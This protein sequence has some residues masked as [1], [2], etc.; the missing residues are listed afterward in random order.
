MQQFLVLQG[1][2]DLDESDRSGLADALT[3]R[4]LR[5]VLKSQNPFFRAKINKLP[6]FPPA[7]VEFSSAFFKRLLFRA[8][9]QGYMDS[10][11]NAL[12]VNVLRRILKRMFYLLDD[13][14][15]LL[16]PV[17]MSHGLEQLPTW[18]R[19]RDITKV[20]AGE[21]GEKLKL[22]VRLR[23][24]ERI[25]AVMTEETSWLGRVYGLFTAVCISV[26]LILVLSTQSPFPYGT[27][28]VVIV[29]FTLDYFARMW[30]AIFVR[31]F[32]HED[33]LLQACVPETDK[34][35]NGRLPIT[36]SSATRIYEFVTAPLNVIDIISIMP[37]WIEQVRPEFF[38]KGGLQLGFLRVVRIIRLSKFMKLGSFQE[39]FMIMGQVFVRSTSAMVAIC[40]TLLCLALMFGAVMSQAEMSF[41]AEDAEHAIWD[42][43]RAWH[44]MV[45]STPAEWSTPASN[46]VMWVAGRLTNMQG[47]MRMKHMIPASWFNQILVHIIGILKGF[48]FLLPLGQMQQYFK[49]ASTLSAQYTRLDHEVDDEKGSPPGQE[50][51]HDPH[52][53][54]ALV[55]VFTSDRFREMKNDGGTRVRGMLNLPLRTGEDA[56]PTN[57][58]CHIV[59]LTE[60]GIIP[61]DNREPGILFEVTWLREERCETFENGVLTIRAISGMYFPTLE[62]GLQWALRISVP[63]HLYSFEPKKYAFSGLSRGSSETPIWEFHMQFDIDWSHVD[64]LHTEVPNTARRIGDNEMELEQIVFEQLLQLRRMEDRVESK[65]QRRK[66]KVLF[67]FSSRGSSVVSSREVSR[68]NRAAYLVVDRNSYS[69]ESSHP[70]PFL[71]DV[72]SDPPRAS[73]P[74]SPLSPCQPS[75]EQARGMNGASF[76]DTYGGDR[77]C[78]G[79][80]DFLDPERERV[81][82][83]AQDWLDS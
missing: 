22:V 27:R 61:D 23:T 66:D 58:F 35:P 68:D 46:T 76:L 36:N 60:T 1:L 37:F 81:Q 45:N 75:R 16:W 70:G 52:A 38:E 40:L 15:S 82:R 4:Q 41:I 80:V 57:V 21:Q 10:P 13:D 50:W 32:L 65:L 19:W 25:Y 74:E 56:E 14:T 18:I 34:D 53:P 48:V 20:L 67:P 42:N 11:M 59:G 51:V 26:S 7:E 64:S 69:L 77:R 39:D 79:A 54:I 72:E 2:N 49:D 71:D 73:S 9:A 5:K 24:A 28:A 47:S 31:R 3:R 63:E 30:T 62:H 29:F 55:E 17:E 6:L 33:L 43:D 12:H 83:R 78:D 44:D 8:E